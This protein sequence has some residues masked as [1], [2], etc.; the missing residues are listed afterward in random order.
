MTTKPNRSDRRERAKKSLTLVWITVAILTILAIALLTVLVGPSPPKTITLA[1]GARGGAYHEFAERYRDALASEGITVDVLDTGGSSENLDL[2]SSGKADVAFVQSGTHHLV[3]DPEQLRGIASLYYEPLWIFQKDGPK[4]RH[5]GELA[6]KRLAVGNPGSGT[7]EV[8]H[9]L[10]KRNGVVADDK[11][12]F[13]PLGMTEA[14]DALLKGEID[15]AFFIASPKAEVVH[16]LMTEPNTRL[17]SIKRHKAY[18]RNVLFVTDV[19]IAEGTFDLRNN[20]P[21]EDIVVL[22]TLATLVCNR[23]LHPAVVELLT[24]TAHDLHSGRQLL[25]HGGEFPSPEHLEFTVHEAASDYFRSGP[26]L[27]ARYL[28]FWLANLLKKL[29]VLAI[30]LLTLLLPLMKV[31]PL[32]YKATMR[33]RIHRHYDELDKIED[34][35]DHAQTSEQFDACQQDI[36]RLALTVESGIEV[37][38]TF[39]NE[40]YD[41]RLHIAH[42]GAQLQAKRHEILG[43]A[44]DSPTSEPA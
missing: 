30:P 15:Y 29:L 43:T 5:L 12:M 20:V 32:L 21:D 23:D 4:I 33:K 37:P 19:E 17:V 14:R 10:L 42:V 2:L 22:S 26:S 39:R 25:E 31:A 35:I 1:S 13:L 24:R 41:L 44:A 9:R 11:T 7:Y 18:V 16:E 28:P 27:L 38:T 6:G 8:V 36:Q 34:Q 40:E 3:D